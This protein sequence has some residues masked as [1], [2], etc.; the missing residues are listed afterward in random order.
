MKGRKVDA[1]FYMLE[2]ETLKEGEASIA[3]SSSGENLSMMW[4]RKLGHMSE[5]GLKVLVEQN[6]LLGLTKVSLPFCEHYVTS[7]QHR[8]KFNTSSSRS[9]VILELVHSDV[10][11]PPAT[12]LGGAMYFVS[13]I[14]DYSRSEGM[15]TLS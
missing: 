13:F 1:N 3:S 10:W 15:K 8:L 5:Q 9:K 14:D 4:H 2:E 7:K 12:S 11:Q 6:L